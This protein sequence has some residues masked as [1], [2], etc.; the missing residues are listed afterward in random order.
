MRKKIHLYTDL[1]TIGG[2]GSSGRGQ[3]AGQ[4][5]GQGRRR[6]SELRR[7]R[8]RE[9]DGGSES[10]LRCGECYSYVERFILILCLDFTVIW[11][12]I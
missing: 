5:H 11:P 2:G 6:R 1:I 10:T 7:R 12:D 3:S 4:S 9:G 8:R